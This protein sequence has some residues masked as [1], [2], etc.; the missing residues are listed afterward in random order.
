MKKL[1]RV[2][3]MQRL[4]KTTGVDKK[5]PVAP[6]VQQNFSQFN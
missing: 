4:F 6:N 1:G 2:A 3:K 5:Q